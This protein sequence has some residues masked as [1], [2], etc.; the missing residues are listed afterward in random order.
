MAEC[1]GL[2]LFSTKHSR[3]SL[4]RREQSHLLRVSF[5]HTLMRDNNAGMRNFAK[6]DLEASHK[7]LPRV[8]HRALLTPSWAACSSSRAPSSW[9]ASWSPA[10]QT[11]CSF[12]PFP[13]L[14][15]IN[16]SIIIIMSTMTSTP[17]KCTA[18]QVC[19]N[20]HGK[21]HPSP[22]STR[23]PTFSIHACYLDGKFGQLSKH[24]TLR[25]F[26]CCSLSCQSQ[27]VTFIKCFWTIQL[28]C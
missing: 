10:P 8:P 4:L 26:F 3:P 15:W 18:L 13:P 9:L 27:D 2:Y 22:F 11:L 25:T 28:V 6:H 7:R 5:A 12:K 21:M 14:R 20:E 16:I 1:W 19:C 24:F 23:E 17:A